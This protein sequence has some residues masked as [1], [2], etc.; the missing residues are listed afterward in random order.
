MCFAHDLHSALDVRAR[1]IPKTD[2]AHQ[3]QLL[4]ALIDNLFLQ[5]V[6]GREVNLGSKQRA[7]TQSKDPQA[8]ASPAVLDRTKMRH[9]ERNDSAAGRESRGASSKETV[10][11]AFDEHHTFIRL[12][13]G[14]NDAEHP[15]V[16]RVEGDLEVRRM[17]IHELACVRQGLGKTKNS[18][19]GGVPDDLAL[20]ERSIV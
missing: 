20:H 4:E 5:R 18:R 14:M 8:L 11:R 10:W 6:R 17:T 15:L 1:R 9:V 19:V 13:G 3:R 7:T 12:V 2:E 16:P